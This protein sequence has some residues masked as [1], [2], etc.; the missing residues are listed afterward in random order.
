MKRKTANMIL[1]KKFDGFLASIEDEKIR[2]TISDGS[3]ITGGA[4]ASMLL[5]EKVNDFDIYFRTKETAAA[6]TEYF[7]NQFDYKGNEKAPNLSFE[8]E[9]DRVRIVIKSAGVASEDGNESYG[10]YESDDPE[11]L[12]A[13]EYVDE[14]IRAAKKEDAEKKAFRPVFIS[15]NAITLSKDVQLIVRFFGE[16]DEIH[17]NYDFVHCTNYWTSWDR[18]LVLNQDALEALLARELKYIGSK[19]PVCSVL[20]LRKFINRGWTINAGQALKIMF[21]I[22]ELDLSNMTVLR[23]Q[24]T[25]VDM[26]YF[27]EVISLLKDKQEENGGKPIDA[28]YLATIID[29]IF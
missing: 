9:E 11:G 1:S 16:P 5:G 22:S 12:R 15:E 20:R 8:V 4:I 2:Q 3:I 24:L 25:G 19:Y 17:D 21:Q 7:L 14:Q 23:E 28:T 13:L 10:Y 6:V 27:H 29:R 18:K 26:A